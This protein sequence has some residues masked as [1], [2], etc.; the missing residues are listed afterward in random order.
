[1]SAT[2]SGARHAAAASAAGC[3]VCQ[4]HL[5]LPQRAAHPQPNPAATSIAAPAEAP[6]AAATARAKPGPA[7]TVAARAKRK[8]TSLPA[9]PD[10][11]AIV[12]DLRRSLQLEQEEAEAEAD[13][14]LDDCREA[15]YASGS[16]SV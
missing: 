9:A 10:E 14:Q 11:Q 2:V 6:V 1:M 7:A 16:P 12:E 13:A 4:R 15:E 8:I 3:K 5:S